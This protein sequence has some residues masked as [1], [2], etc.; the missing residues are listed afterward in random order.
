V[1]RRPRALIPLVDDG[2]PGCQGASLPGRS[3]ACARALTQQQPHRPAPTAGDNVNSSTAPGSSSNSKR[4]RWA[5]STFGPTGTSSSSSVDKGKGREQADDGQDRRLSRVAPPSFAFPGK[6]AKPLPKP[7]A[8]AVSR[9][10]GRLPQIPLKLPDV[11]GE[12]PDSRSTKRPRTSTGSILGRLPIPLAAAPPSPNERA[13]TP[14]PKTR[15]LSLATSFS[16][17]G[18]GGGSGSKPASLRRTMALSSVVPPAALQTPTKVKA[19][20]TERELVHGLL[21]IPQ[22]KERMKEEAE[23]STSAA[24]AGSSTARD[25]GSAGGVKLEDALLGVSPRKARKARG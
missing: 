2:P 15:P 11:A 24:A 23:A 5:T 7:M 22:G 18:S 8:L 14:A 4:P 1:R 19:V 3:I 10:A 21:A 12:S 17:G 20:K 16:G 9:A 6:S 25:G 13:T